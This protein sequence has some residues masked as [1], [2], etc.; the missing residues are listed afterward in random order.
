MTMAI[1]ITEQNDQ[2]IT[3]DELLDW[4]IQHVDP[5]DDASMVAASSRL[6]SLRNNRDFIRV[7]LRDELRA[8]ADGRSSNRQHSP[9]IYI[10]G[11]RAG[12]HGSFTV[13]SVVW[14][15]PLTTHERSRLLQ[16]RA[17]S[18]SVLHDHNFA[19]LTVGYLGAGYETA[20]YEY[21]ARTVVGY[22]GESVHLEY[23]ETTTLSPGKILYF[24]PRRDI[25]LQ[26]YPS[27]LSIS[28][29]LIGEC[30]EIN[31]IPQFEFDADARKIVALLAENSVN[32]QV[33]PLDIVS[34]VG[35]NDELLGL[36][37]R[38]ARTHPAEHV[39]SAAYRALAVVSP[40]DIEALCQP[41]LD[42]RS[43][44]VRSVV[45]SMLG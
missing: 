5:R 27:E 29:N 2:I 45:E 8:L 13:R 31:S 4:V 6:Y 21:D 33:L 17:F 10:H 34:L 36:V 19:L 35:A 40:D 7:A 32:R 11:T 44:L 14:S 39:R 1:T 37:E 18:Y 30:P 28:L 25:H 38:L 24:R 12:R 23:L 42:D 26:R 16:D 15:P 43:P 22:P 20:I 9:Q 3:P 41:G